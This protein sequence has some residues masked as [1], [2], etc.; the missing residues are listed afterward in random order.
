MMVLEFP[1]DR[2]AKLEA[3]CSPSA[4]EFLCQLKTHPCFTDLL[5]KLESI[6]FTVF[7]SDV[8]EAYLALTKR[9]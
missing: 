4:L 3:R 6:P 5:Q 9:Q 7:R 2:V 1:E 8:E